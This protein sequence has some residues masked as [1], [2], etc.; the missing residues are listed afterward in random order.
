MIATLFVSPFL[1]SQQS[2]AEDYKIN[3]SIKNE[4]NV[5]TKTDVSIKTED[6]KIETTVKIN[7]NT[8]K[9][10]EKISGEPGDKVKVCLEESD[11]NSEYC[12]TK[13]L[14]KDEDSTVKFNLEY[15][16]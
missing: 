4:E 5:D 12:Q 7:D 16:D 1:M 8:E 14:P 3:I 15:I 13:K 2:F 9:I 10:K 6:D 11:D